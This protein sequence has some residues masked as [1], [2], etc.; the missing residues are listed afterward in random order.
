MGHGYHHVTLVPKMADLLHQ[1]N[2]RSSDLQVQLGDQAVK[3]I[4]T[5]KSWIHQEPSNFAMF[6]LK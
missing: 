1:Q 2:M 5:R 4:S 3:M 6:G